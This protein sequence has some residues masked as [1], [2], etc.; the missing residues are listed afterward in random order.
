MGH[1]IEESQLCGRFLHISHNGIKGAKIKIEPFWASTGVHCE[2]KKLSHCVLWLVRSF[3]SKLGQNRSNVMKFI[4]VHHEV[5]DLN[6]LG[7]NVEDVF[8]K[9]HIVY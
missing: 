6:K 3:E 1:Y 5:V 8:V 7:R 2:Q 9:A 4:H